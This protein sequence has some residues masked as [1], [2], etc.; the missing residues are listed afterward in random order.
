MS[1]DGSDGASGVGG[2]GGSNAAGNDNSTDGLGNAAEAAADALG[3]A[4]D[5]VADAVTGMLGSVT[6]AAGLSDAI[7]NLA[8][9][10][11]LDAKDLQGLVGAAFMGAVTG[12]LPGA[13]MGVVNALVG[14]SLQDAAR[15]AVSS[16]LPASMQPLANMAIDAF[17]GK[18]PGAST[19]SNLQ[20]VLGTLA[21][22][23]LTNGRVPGLGDIASVAREMRSL[24]NVAS[25]VMDSAMRGDF[26]DAVDAVSTLE[27]SLNRSFAEASRISA[28]VASQFGRGNGVYADGGHGDFGDAVE[29]LAV[30]TAQL[31]AQ[32]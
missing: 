26:A 12:G 29:R 1:S 18:I 9:M 8:D 14:G 6:D 17:A 32:R 22:G 27:G 31:M 19:S 5:A 20:G 3:Q 16:N 25:S 10:L 13:V 4:V 28:D 2:G 24:S 7:G 15:D 30:S 23:A 21:T 11:G